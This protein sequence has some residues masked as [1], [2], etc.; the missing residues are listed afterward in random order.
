MKSRIST[1]L[2]TFHFSTLSPHRLVNCSEK[3][4]AYEFRMNSSFM[5]RQNKWCDWPSTTEEFNL[6]HSAAKPYPI[7]SASH[8]MQVQL[9]SSIIFFPTHHPRIHNPRVLYHKRWHGRPFLPNP[10]VY[11]LLKFRIVLPFS[12][13]EIKLLAKECLPSG[14]WSSNDCNRLRRNLPHLTNQSPP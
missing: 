6:A 12:I 8:A 13:C 1:L 2:R 3:S 7:L 14:L 4:C 10:N 9:H 5:Q 11:S